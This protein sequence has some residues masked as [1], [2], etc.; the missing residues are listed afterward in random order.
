MPFAPTGRAL[1]ACLP[2]QLLPAPPLVAQA[3]RPFACAGDEEIVAHPLRTKAPRTVAGGRDTWR[4][5]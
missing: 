3:G 4:A 1:A 5:P 2:L